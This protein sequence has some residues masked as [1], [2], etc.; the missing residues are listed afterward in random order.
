MD[1]S[2]EEEVFEDALEE[3]VLP[4]PAEAENRSKAL[5]SKEVSLPEGLAAARESIDKFLNNHFDEAR[6]IVQP[7]ADCSIYHALGYGVFM[8]LKA[9]MTFEQK[10]IEEASAVLSQACENIDSYRHKRSKS[11]GLVDT[12]GKLIKKA[13]PDYDQYT[14]NQ[15]HAELCYAEILLLKAV[16]TLCEDETL[17]SFVKAGLKV[18]TCYQSFRECWTILQER[19]TWSN[20][21]HRKDFE[22]GVRFGVGC[23]NLMISL[24]PARVMKLLEFIGFRGNKDAGIGELLR[25]YHE[26]DGLRQF[27]ASLVLLG[28]HLVLSHFLGNEIEQSNIELCHHILEEKLARYPQGAFFLFFQGR[29]HFIEGEMSQAIH[30][31]KAACQSQN[32]WP[33]FHHVCYWELIW[34]H[35]FKQDWWGAALYAHRLLQE[36]KWSR[37]FY[38]YQKAAMMCMVQ[39]ELTIEERREQIE[40]MTNIP[41]WKQKIAGKSLPMEKFALRKSERFLEQG[42]VLVL[43]ALELIY[44]W[45]G[46]KVLGKSWSMIEPM[47]RLIEQHLSRVEK[48]KDQ[49]LFYLEDFCLLTLLKGVCLK[50]MKSPL[51]AEE[52]FQAVSQHRGTLKRDT[53]L[54]PY[55]MYERG[56]LLKDQ[57]SFSEALDLLEKTKNDFKD[58]LLQSRLHFRIHSAQI[59]I[60]AKLKQSKRS[61]SRKSSAGQESVVNGLDSMLALPSTEQETIRMIKNPR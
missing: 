30:W 57:G 52:C 25:V 6:A 45:N 27:L 28:Y 4:K 50:H 56:L 43:P 2:D 22:S 21:Q 16:L 40:L 54:I 5:N 13:A 59:E 36:S 60:R 24:L 15:V 26:K 29:Y 46:F 58:Y 53:F 35:Q 39:E 38:A 10:H 7:L 18:R 3:P 49:R 31:Y 1:S 23:F 41:Q 48:E 9:V 37:C 51:Q 47:F 42:N 11:A 8:Y 34:A 32:E 33:Q 19:T 12:L 20:Q 61:T 55:A 44:V 17:V 14:D